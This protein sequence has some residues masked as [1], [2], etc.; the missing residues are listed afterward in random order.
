VS[1]A[2]SWFYFG[3]GDQAGHYVWD[4]HRNR[5]HGAI[6][7][8]LSQFDGTL[9]AER[10]DGLYLAT[11]TRF[12]GIGANGYTALAWW[13]HSVDTRPGSNSILF[14]PSARTSGD[15]CLRGLEVFF[16]WVQARLPQPLQFH[17]SAELD[18]LAHRS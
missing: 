1:V 13:D 18:L 17:P 3:C 8:R 15:A 11:I 16:P 9:C 5:A 7:R 12:S 6:G 4:R 2:D 10:G 14:C